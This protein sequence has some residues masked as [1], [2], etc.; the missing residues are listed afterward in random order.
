V[1]G[2]VGIAALAS[3]L[4]NRTAYHRAVVGESLQ[5]SSA[6]WGQAGAAVTAHLRVIG[7]GAVEARL[8]AAATMARHAVETASIAAFDDAF[9]AG[10]LIVACGVIPALFLRSRGGAGASGESA[11]HALAD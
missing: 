3:I 2:S 9:L 10:A 5:A 4:G 1:A 6:A 11:A 8:A 7:Y